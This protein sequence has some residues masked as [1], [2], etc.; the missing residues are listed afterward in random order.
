VALADAPE[1]DYNWIR[2]G[3]DVILGKMNNDGSWGGGAGEPGTTEATGLCLLALVAAGENK[4]VPA[5]LARAAVTEMQ[6]HLDEAIGE[7]DRLRQDVEK[8]VQDE[9]GQV[10]GERNELLKENKRLK[11]D[12]SKLKSEI[13]KLSEVAESAEL[14]RRRLEREREN[15]EMFFRESRAMSLR[16]RIWS[17]LAGLVHTP[18]LAFIGLVS[19]LAEV[20]L[21]LWVSRWPMPWWLGLIFAAPIVSLITVIWIAM[22]ETPILLRRYSDRYYPERFQMP[23]R[24]SELRLMYHDISA[25]WSPDLREEV[26]Y[27]LFRELIEAP[28]QIGIRYIEDLS[29]RLNLPP[30]SRSMLVSWAERVLR[31]DPSDRRILFEQ[32]QRASIR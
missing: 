22:S 8:R 16:G 32:I 12:I 15:L 10:V 25:M 18:V 13:T 11:G 7:R 31:L 6:D 28:P 20:A 23:S 1:S 14:M 17:I 4:Y 2:E 5:R 19:I 21:F 3:V 24:L 30:Y 29:L 26:G 27:R 9:C